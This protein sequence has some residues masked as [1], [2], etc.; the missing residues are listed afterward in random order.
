MAKQKKVSSSKDAKHPGVL[1]INELNRRGFLQKDY[2]KE[3]GMVYSQFNEIVKG[4]RPITTQL[5]LKVEATLEI[6]AQELLHLQA[7]YDLEKSRIK[8]EQSEELENL[9]Q[10][11]D[12]KKFVPIS[13]FKKLNVIQGENIK[14]DIEKLCKIYNVDNAQQLISKI[15]TEIENIQQVK[16]RKS[17]KYDTNFNNMVAYYNY[18][19]FLSA[20][21][22][23]NIK[24]FHI[25]NLPVLIEDLRRTFSLP[26]V[27]SN[28]ERI[29]SS[30]GI[31]F[32]S[33]PR[34]D[35]VP[36]DGMSFY[37]KNNPTIVL[38]LRHS[39]IDNFAFTLFHEILHVTE[40]LSKNRGKKYIDYSE[41]KIVDEDELQADEFSRNCLIPSEK[42]Q[43]FIR[44]YKYNDSAIQSFASSIGINPAIVRGRLCFEGHLPYKG[45]TS[46]SYEI[47]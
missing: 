43:A 36:V 9:R 19:F 18:V 3:I 5:A 23:T 21:S 6:S 2:S 25:D 45:K 26:N 33:K 28:V 44:T 30:V 32:I 42:W 13:Y 40:H 24:P 17:T 41:S 22:S 8:H 46:I 10:W 16:F 15:D 27:V 37:T 29:L 35:Q 1:I 12:V 31:I 7:N 34:P 20:E 11:K 47:Q 38:S 4:N 14:H 39:R